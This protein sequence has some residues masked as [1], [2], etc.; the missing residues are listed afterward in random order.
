[1]TFDFRRI[2]IVVIPPKSSNDQ[3]WRQ[4]KS[5][6]RTPLRVPTVR[7]LQ[8]PDGY[9]EIPVQRMG[10]LESDKLL[11]CRQDDES[12]YDHHNDRTGG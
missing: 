10:L 9:E 12:D 2:F 4:G 7:R 6:D 1:V 11:L 8:S 3:V 5:S